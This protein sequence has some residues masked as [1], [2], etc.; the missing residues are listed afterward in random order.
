VDVAFVVDE[1]TP[2]IQIEKIVL[3]RSF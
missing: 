3:S 2:T 1:V